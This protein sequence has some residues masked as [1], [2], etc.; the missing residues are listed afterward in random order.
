VNGAGNLLDGLLGVFGTD[1]GGWVFSSLGDLGHGG[2]L[3]SLGGFRN[4]RIRGHRCLWNRWVLSSLGGLGSNR[5]GGHRCLRDGRVCRLARG[6]R[7]SRVVCRVCDRRS[8]GWVCRHVGSR[9]RDDGLG[10]GHG[11]RAGSVNAGGPALRY[12]G[13][14]GRLCALG[15]D[16]RNVCGGYGG[17]TGG[18]NVDVGS[19]EVLVSDVEVLDS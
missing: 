9:G 12:V 16:G 8:S 1:G 13:R 2:V 10:D 3:S 5:V 7:L 18:A 14:A 11:N 15:A 17:Q 19:C 6:D 4:G